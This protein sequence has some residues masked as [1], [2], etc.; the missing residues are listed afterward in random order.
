MEMTLPRHDRCV[1]SDNRLSPRAQS[2]GWMAMS[3][4]LH[5][6][7]Y[8]LARSGTLALF[9]SKTAGFESSSALPLAVGTVSPFSVALLSYYS[10]LLDKRGPRSTLRF[11]TFMFAAVLTACSLILC[12]FNTN[13][14][15]GAWIETNGYGR[16][17]S[18]VAVFFLFVYQNASVRL[19]HSQHWSFISSVTSKD[20]ARRWFAPITGL[21]SLTSTIAAGSISY[22]LESLNLFGLLI[23]A[24]AIMLLGAKC[25]DTAYRIAATHNFTPIKEIDD[26]PEK[27]IA[28]GAK[29]SERDEWQENGKSVSPKRTSATACADGLYVKARTLFQRVPV[30]GALFLEVLLCQSLSS[31]LNFIFLVKTKEGIPGDEERAGWSGKVSCGCDS[32]ELHFCRMLPMTA[33]LIMLLLFFILYSAML[34]P[35]VYLAFYSFL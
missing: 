32:I 20:E 31:L 24:A 35:T 18:R 34:G 14:G 10:S 28:G 11:T 29:I 12:I 2:V 3:A 17:I 19:L 5:F 8:E 23:T 13:E 16:N 33:S 22:L 25:S 30:L 21:A 9:T 15:D 26:N 6:A 1:R 7:A 4:G 27:E